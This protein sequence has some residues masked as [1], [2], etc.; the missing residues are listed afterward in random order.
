MGPLV[1]LSEDGESHRL[2]SL[3]KCQCKQGYEIVCTAPHMLWL[4]TLV[5]WA[6]GCIQ[7]W[8]EL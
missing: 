5:K 4:G 6:E 8:V 1:L 3:F 7:Q 2:C